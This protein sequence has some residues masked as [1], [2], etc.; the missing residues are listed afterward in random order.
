[1]NECCEY[2]IPEYDTCTFQSVFSQ[3]NNI[4]LLTL[5]G[6]NIPSIGDGFLVVVLQHDLVLVIRLDKVPG[7]FLPVT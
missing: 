7:G 5:L 3:E 6:L 1:V 2:A 4:F